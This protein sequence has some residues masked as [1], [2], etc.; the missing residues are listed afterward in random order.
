VQFVKEAVI[1]VARCGPIESLLFILGGMQETSRRCNV[2][3]CWALNLGASAFNA[4]EPCVYVRGEIAS[5]SLRPGYSEAC[6]GMITT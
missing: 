3:A 1:P 6:L 2:Q 4:G 5:L